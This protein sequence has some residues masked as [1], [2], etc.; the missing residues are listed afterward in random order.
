M[1]RKGAGRDRSQRTN[2]GHQDY[3]IVEIGQNTEK[4]SGDL[5]RFAVSQNPEVRKTRYNN[6][7]NNNNNNRIKVEER[8]I[9]RTKK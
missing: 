7:N 1:F 5:R 6:N 3:S 9:G 2:R 4:S 8:M